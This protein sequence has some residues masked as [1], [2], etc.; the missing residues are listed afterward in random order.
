MIVT[1]VPWATKAGTPRV[2]FYLDAILAENLAPIGKFIKK[3]FGV[4][5]LVSGGG[6]TRT[7]KSRI[8]FGVGTYI[9]WIIAGGEMDFTRNDDEK[10]SL[11]YPSG[12]I[13]KY[14]TKPLNFTLDNVVFSSEELRTKSTELPKYSVIALDEGRK[15][16]EAITASSKDNREMSQF[17]D[18]VGQRNQVFLIVLPDF[19]KLSADLCTTRS[20]F[21][22]DVYLDENY[23]RGFFNYFNE[24]QK[25]FLYN[26]AKRMVGIVGK[27]KCGYPTFSGKFVDFCPFDIQKYEL[28]KLKALEEKTNKSKREINNLIQRNCLITMYKTLTEKT[29]EEIAEDIS[30]EL[31]KKITVRIIDHA[32]Q[33]FR[34]YIE[35]IE[36]LNTEKIIKNKENSL[37]KGDGG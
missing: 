37:K 27:Y 18:E 21:L 33:D 2:G 11:K 3:D 17:L 7:G 22:I 14:P 26:R 32:I 15:G 23:N 4:I 1:N 35:K 12:R 19:F 24:V 31:G 5:G 36:D 9:A 13:K 10:Q 29:H 6:K 8:M 30:E 20:L 34:S 25:D 16:N 28:K